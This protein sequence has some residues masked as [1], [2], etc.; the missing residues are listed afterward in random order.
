MDL[1]LGLLSIKYCF[2]FDGNGGSAAVTG[3][4]NGGG[5]G[6]GSQSG[7]GGL[8]KRNGSAATAET[9]E[10]RRLDGR[11][12]SIHKR[13]TQNNAATKRQGDPRGG[14]A[15]RDRELTPRSLTTEYL[16]L[17]PWHSVSGSSHADRA[18]N[19]PRGGGCDTKALSFEVSVP[20]ASPEFRG[21]RT[22]TLELPGEPRPWGRPTRTVRFGGDAL[23]A[24]KEQHMRIDWIIRTSALGFMAVMILAYRVLN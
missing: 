1:D 18:D 20:R 13:N 14:K 2:A 7:A 16:P 11:H 12:F 3:R 8:Q 6:F 24:P 5:V 21:E 15:S 9:H 19:I 23:P 22:N 17:S 4:Q 10:P